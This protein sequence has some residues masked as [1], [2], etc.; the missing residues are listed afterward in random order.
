MGCALFLLV[1][2]GKIAFHD[3]A[4]SGKEAV[5]S[6]R[7]LFASTE[8]TSFAANGDGIRVC[9]RCFRLFSNEFAGLQA[10]ESAFDLPGAQGSLECFRVGAGKQRSM[11]GAASD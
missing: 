11:T 6:R 3:A 5:F 4:M 2:G 7:V 9:V 8:K 1:L 10:I